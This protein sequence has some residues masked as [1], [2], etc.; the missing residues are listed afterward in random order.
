MFLETEGL[1]AP[2]ALILSVSA[3][4][5][6]LGVD[7]FE[8]DSYITYRINKAAMLSFAVRCSTAR[9]PKPRLYSRRRGL[10][11]SGSPNP[12]ISVHKVEPIKVYDQEY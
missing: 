9:D 12:S 2:I 3:R 7:V 10:A 11:A 8:T 6:I 4:T 1:S 5:I